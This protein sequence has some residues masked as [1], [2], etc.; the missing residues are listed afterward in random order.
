MG[1]DLKPAIVLSVKHAPIPE[2]LA[3]VLEPAK[4]RMHCGRSTVQLLCDL[5]VRH[6]QVVV[7]LPYALDHKS[8]DL[9]APQLGLGFGPALDPWLLEALGGQ[10][11][12]SE[13][14]QLFA[15][16]DR[17]NCDR[18]RLLLFRKYLLHHCL[19]HRCSYYVIIATSITAL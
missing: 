14:L 12:A 6:L 16:R 8:S 9:V 19:H 2:L 7:E 3:I 15:G 11:A 5:V 13:L 17:S 4:Y 18:L 10:K 1:D